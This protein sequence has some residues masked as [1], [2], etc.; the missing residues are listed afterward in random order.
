MEAL[1]LRWRIAFT[2]SSLNGI[3]G[4]VADG[5][6]ISLLPR[7]AVSRDHRIIDGERDLPV[8]DNYEIGL[9]HR[10]DADDA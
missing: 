6:G 7:R 5:I 9:L 3:Q 4:A 1:G 10:A 8:I 2:S